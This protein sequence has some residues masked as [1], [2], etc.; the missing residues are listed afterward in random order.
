MTRSSSPPFR[1]VAGLVTALAIAL[2]AACANSTPRVEVA[3]EVRIDPV[4]HD[5]LPRSVLDSGVIRIGTDASYAP[6]SSFGPD[7]RTII[8]MEPDLGVEIGRVLG[9]RVEFVNADFTKLLTR[10]AN[11]GLDLGM[12]AMTDTRERAKVAD[13]VNYF[14][15]GTSIVVQRGNPAGV[16]DIKDLCGQVVAVEK[17]TT[18][19]DL[20]GRAQRNCPGKPIDVKTYPTNSDALVQLRTGRAVAVLNDLPPAVFLVNDPRTK[21][22]YQL[23]STT[24]YEP[25]LY[26]IVVAKSQPGLREAIRG[27]CAKLLRN[28]VY[29]DVLERWDVSDG[30]ID[31]VSV[32]SN[33]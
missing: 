9:V 17:G 27:A 15:A 20:L 25:G 18:Q 21:S 8:G 13:F 2:T 16:T 19:V 5:L 32:N 30:A 23:A 29:A 28:G 11:G 7:G 26:G 4:L 33:R 10:V 14:S 31:R 22:H 12:S 6:M 24:T 3:P 1:A